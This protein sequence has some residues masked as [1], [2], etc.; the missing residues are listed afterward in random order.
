MITFEQAK[1]LT[2]DQVVYTIKE[3]KIKEAKITSITTIERGT[4]RTAFLRTSCRICY[5][6]KGGTYEYVDWATEDFSVNKL[7]LSKE[8]VAKALIA[9][10]SDK[11]MDLEERLMAYQQK[12]IVAKK[13]GGI[14]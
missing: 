11:M 7:Y 10:I 4:R 1:T 5:K 8:E 3:N 12:I 13:F 2:E 6:L 9:D 14:Q